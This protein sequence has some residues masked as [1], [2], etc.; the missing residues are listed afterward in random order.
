VVILILPLIAANA[1]LEVARFLER[2]AIVVLAGELFRLEDKLH[3]L[4][5]ARFELDPLKPSKCRCGIR[6]F[7]LLD[8][9]LS[10]CK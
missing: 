6:K 10:C 2:F 1:D 7:L 4:R 9:S 5:L 8:L 3:N